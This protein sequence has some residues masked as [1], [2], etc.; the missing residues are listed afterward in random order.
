MIQSNLNPH[1]VPPNFIADDAVL[2]LNLLVGCDVDW[3][4]GCEDEDCNSINKNIIFQG[5]IYIYIYI[6]FLNNKLPKIKKRDYSYPN[7]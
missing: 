2:I 3:E 5:I 4:G 1:F 6:F 7:H